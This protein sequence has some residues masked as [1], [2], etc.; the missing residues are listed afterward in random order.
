MDEEGNFKESLISDLPGLL[1][2]YEAAHLMVH[3]ED[4][5]DEALAFTTAHLRSMLSDDSDNPLK[6]QIIRT[7]KRPIRKGIPRVEARHYISIYQEDDSHDESLLKLAKLDYNMLQSLH[8][9][10]LSEC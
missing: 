4:I 3:G 9:K 5:L 8:K 7:L 1:A 10:Q 2:L 6:E